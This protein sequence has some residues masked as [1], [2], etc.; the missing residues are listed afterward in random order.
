MGTQQLARVSV[1]YDH[2]ATDSDNRMA[3]AVACWDKY[4]T[5]TDHAPRVMVPI[6]MWD[7]S[8]GYAVVPANIIGGAL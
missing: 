1:S 5:A 8:T 4:A 7:G 6:D 2:A 3:A